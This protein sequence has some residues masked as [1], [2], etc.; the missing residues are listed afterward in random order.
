[1]TL[2]FIASRHPKKLLD[3]LQ[4]IRSF[5][6]EKS[7]QGIYNIIGDIMPIQLIDSRKL[8][9]DENV[10]LKSLNNRLDPKVIIKIGEKVKL[11]DKEVRLNAYMNVIAQANIWAIEEALKMSNA[12][13]SLDDVFERTGL[14]AKWEARAEAK[15]KEQEA[16]NIAKN[17]VNAGFPLETVVSMTNLDPEK[18][19]ELFK[20]EQ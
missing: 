12:A 20:L 18:V 14:A 9:T 19:K 2:T 11:K 4:K 16:K 7:G 3:H 8:T 1:M 6:V 5:I 15:G 17:M 10:W 13:L